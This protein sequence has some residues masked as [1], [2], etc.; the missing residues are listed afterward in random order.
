M[1]S[2]GDNN[3]SFTF[4]KKLKYLLSK[5]V[6]C[7]PLEVLTKCQVILDN[8]NVETFSGTTQALCELTQLLKKC[9]KF[10]FLMGNNSLLAQAYVSSLMGNFS[11]DLSYKSKSKVYGES[12]SRRS[13]VLL[14]REIN[15]ILLRQI[16]ETDDFIYESGYP[17]QGLETIGL[18]GARNSFSRVVDYQLNDFINK[19]DTV[20]DLGA[21]SGFIGLLAS[22][23]M[24]CHS[25]NLDRNRYF[26]E[27]GE[28]VADYLDVKNLSDFVV[29]DANKLP[30]LLKGKKYNHV[31]SFAS[32]YTDDAGIRNTYEQHF[33]LMSNFLTPKGKIYFES[34]C[35]DTK[36]PELELFIKKVN[37]K[38]SLKVLLDKMLDGES[39]RLII[40]ES[41]G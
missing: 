13:V 11:S 19:G 14:I 24:S 23:I 40:L 34:H 12:Y 10:L 21:N 4:R 27:I 1:G 41:L 15:S 2:K 25:T 31:F 9:N 33:N 29:G 38:F 26:L 35:S 3:K 37:E 30:N 16:K 7:D 28:V 20:L 32:H 36:S 17:Y 6:G 5:F 18:F 39:R 22:Q 8:P